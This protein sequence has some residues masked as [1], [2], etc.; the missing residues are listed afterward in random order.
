MA[1]TDASD[2]DLGPWIRDRYSISTD[3]AL[4][5]RGAVHRF[6][7]ES[8]WAAERP[9]EVIDRSIDGSLTFGLYHD[10]R[11]VGM[12]RVVTDLATFAWLCDVFIEPDHRG[13]GL[14]QWLVSVVTEHPSLQGFRTWLLG[15]SYSQ[16]LYARFGF[17]EVEPG[18][19]MVRRQTQGAEVGRTASPTASVPGPTLPE[20]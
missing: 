16:S 18:R 15:T 13:A 5:D 19:F 9:A 6:L 10:G 11:Q 3:P 2:P 17:V 7:A 12:A 20:R 4:I 8:Y 14:G 1:T